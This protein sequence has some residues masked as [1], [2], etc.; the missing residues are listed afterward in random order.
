[1]NGGIGMKKQIKGNI[2]VMAGLVLLA[3]LFSLAP[4]KKGLA[5]T[6]TISPKTK[7]CDNTVHA[8]AYNK[9]TKNYWTIRSYL[10]KIERKKGGTLVLK[11]GTYK[12]TNTLYVPSNTHIILKDG[13]VLKKTKTT[14]SK[15]MPAA[16][17]MIQFLRD[18]RAKKKAVVGKYNGEKNIT[19][20]GE[21][22]ASI[23]LCGLKMGNKDVIG[24]IMGHNQNV[25]IENVTFKNMRYGHLIEMDASKNVTIKNCTFT[26]HKASGK[27][28]KEAINLDT[29][30]KK[31]TGFKSQWSKMDGT[32]NY[33][34][35]ITGCT[36][37]NLEVG[38]GT[39]RYT[40][41]SYHTNVTI[42]GCTFSNDQTAF[43]V[44]NWKNATITQNTIT[45]ITPNARYPYAFF[46]AGVQGINFSYNTFKNCGTYGGTRKSKQLL[47]F[48][49]GAGYNANQTTYGP[50]YSSITQ[51]QAALFKT[52][53]TENC[54]IIRTYNCPYDIDFTNDGNFDNSNL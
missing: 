49:C 19:I 1:M 31:R 43:R 22:T 7:P 10:R 28:N 4:A 5:K 6:Y 46:M 35:S 16:S 52:N 45:N 25:T 40:G 18:S 47:Q 26:G 14:G 38:V 8:R 39:H 51:E 41:N 53:T 24:I 33:G 17:S 20:T 2:F 27:N 30:D 23:D 13:A 37:S 44:L 15:I 34:V 3:V 48:W 12:I 42:S 29:P 9:K 50:T 36:F 32:S 11:K 54:G 21:G